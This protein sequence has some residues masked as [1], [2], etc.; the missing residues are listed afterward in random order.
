MLDFFG[1]THVAFFGDTCVQQADPHECFCLETQEFHPII[2]HEEAGQTVSVKLFDKEFSPA[3]I[4]RLKTL[5][6]DSTE[7][8]Y[9]IFQFLDAK[10]SACEHTWAEDTKDGVSQVLKDKPGTRSGVR[11]KIWTNGYSIGT[12]VKGV[13]HGLYANATPDHDQAFEYR[14]QKADGLRTIDNQNYVCSG[15]NSYTVCD[16]VDS[17]ILYWEKFES[18]EFPWLEEL[19][20]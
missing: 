14:K 4:E 2:V 12:Y 20:G 11:K 18:L 6:G 1:D 7:T 17:S 16:E 8:T 3:E 10:T 15:N 5:N 13:Y 9:E 19:E